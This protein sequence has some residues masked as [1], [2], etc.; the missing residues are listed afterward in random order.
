M[1]LS[2]SLEAQ[3]SKPTQ[4]TH[5]HESRHYKLPAPVSPSQ[6]TPLP[7]CQPANAVSV[8]GNASRADCSVRSHSFS[9]SRPRSSSE[10]EVIRGLFCGALARAC[11][12]KRNHYEACV[13]VATQRMHGR[14]RCLSL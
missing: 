9:L 12:L 13:S 5:T 1:P 11:A 2:P 4:T 14:E 10:H 6:C 7:I 3:P 8:D